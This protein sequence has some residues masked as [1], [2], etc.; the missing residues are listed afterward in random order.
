MINRLLLG[1]ILTAMALVT[2]PAR[3]FAQE[4]GEAPRKITT[5]VNPQYPALAR[6]MKLGG[7]VKM[8][9]SVAPN[10]SPK[11]IE[12]KGGNPVLIQ[13]A[14]RAIREWKWEPAS[15]ATSEEIE[16]HFDPQ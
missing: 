14:E 9:I 3:C 4:S 1:L 5:R 15:H 8:T 16:L 12:P 10:G 7:T 6:T 11:Q 13:S 2:A